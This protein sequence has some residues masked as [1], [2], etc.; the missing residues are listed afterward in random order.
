MCDFAVNILN[1]N[2]YKVGT[3]TCE[4]ESEINTTDSESCAMRVEI[5][6]KKL[7][8]V[9]RKKFFAVP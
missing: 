1:I 3:A 6:D 5:L 7:F 2:A 4:L 9:P 8:R